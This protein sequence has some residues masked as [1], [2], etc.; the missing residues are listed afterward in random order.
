M[1]QT[2][3]T[4][5]GTLTLPI[6]VRRRHKLHPGDILTIDDTDGIR[7]VKNISF[8]ELRKKNQV[9]AGKLRGYTQG[10]GMLAHVI[11]K[12]GKK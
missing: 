2:V 5:Q 4:S 8:A 12:Y 1:G 11:E 10:D 9:D 6:E 3:L 7:I